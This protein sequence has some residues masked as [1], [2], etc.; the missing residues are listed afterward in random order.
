MDD[1]VERTLDQ[2]DQEE[3]LEQKGTQRC[4]VWNME[5][6]LGREL[7]LTDGSYY[8]PS[9]NSFDLTFSEGGLLWD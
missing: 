4:A 9:C 3:L 8:C 6:E 1:Y 2:V 5:A 7:Q